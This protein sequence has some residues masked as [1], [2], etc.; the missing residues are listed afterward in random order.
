MLRLA[1]VFLLLFGGALD[2]IAAD[3]SSLQKENE[4]LTA[5]L[6]RANEAVNKLET[7]VSN[8]NKATQQVLD[9][10]SGSWIDFYEHEKKLRKHARDILFWQRFAAYVILVL[11]VAVTVLGIFLSFVE[12]KSALS[13]PDKLIRREGPTGDT[14]NTDTAGAK[15]G[16]AGDTAIETIEGASSHLELSL[17]KFQVTSAIT[18]V[19]I[20]VISLA[21]LFLFVDRV[22]EIDPRD[23]SSLHRPISEMEV[24]DT[25]S[26]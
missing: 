20:L 22:F 1:L 4:A 7:R 23:L 17:Q 2:T 16:A 8:Q 15:E 25:A 6:T 26:K 14:M 24:T 12:V 13:V 18:G 11:V 3:I 21:F 5:A 19:V 9:A 10:Y